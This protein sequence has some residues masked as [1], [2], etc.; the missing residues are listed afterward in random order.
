MT[1]RMT[2]GRVAWH[3]IVCCAA[4]IALNPRSLAAAAEVVSVS[5]YNVQVAQPEWCQWQRLEQG[6]LEGLDTFSP[7]MPTS[8]RRAS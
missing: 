7:R 3:A 5:D 6:T 2:G 8:R 1:G 4:G